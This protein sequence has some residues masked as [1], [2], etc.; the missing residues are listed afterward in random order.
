MTRKWAS[1]STAGWVTF[2]D[3]L[4]TQPRRFQKYVIVHEL[5]HLRIANHGRLF[6]ALMTMHVPGW[7]KIEKRGL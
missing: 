1:C 4:V 6:K 5:L 7:R 3:D 2:A